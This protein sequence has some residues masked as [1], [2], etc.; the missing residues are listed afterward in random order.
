MIREGF[1]RTFVL[2]GNGS[3]WI[4]E[5]KHLM[6]CKIRSN[7]VQKSI[8]LQ[9]KKVRVKILQKT[10]KN[11]YAECW[12]ICQEQNTSKLITQ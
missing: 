10:I 3:L 4:L 8:G 11:I 6:F 2:E 5:I 9:R 12:M 7:Y 1:K